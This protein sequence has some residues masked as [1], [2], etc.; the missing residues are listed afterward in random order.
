MAKMGFHKG[1][2]GSPFQT[3]YYANEG[4]EARSVADRGPRIGAGALGRRVT[5]EVQ[6]AG[7]SPA[8]KG[9]KGDAE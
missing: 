8:R 1:S 6:K 7:S 5:M 3:E 9:R 2:S 4:Y